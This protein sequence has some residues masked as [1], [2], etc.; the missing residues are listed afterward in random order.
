MW[1]KFSFKRRSCSQ[2]TRILNSET[3]VLS[4]VIDHHRGKREREELRSTSKNIFHTKPAIK[5]ATYSSMME[6]LPIEIPTPNSKIFTVYNWY[7]QPENSHHLQRTGISVSELQPDINVHEVIYADINAHDTAWD[8]TAN[9]NAR[10]EY[11]VNAAMD[12]NRIFHNDQEQP[13]R[14]DPA[15]GTFFSPDVTVVHATFRDIYDLKPH[16]TLSS[17][18]HPILI[19]IHFQTEKL[20]GERFVWD[21][22][23]GDLAVFKPAVDEQL[24]G[25]GLRY[26]ESF[27]RM[28]RSSCKAVIASAKEHIGMKAV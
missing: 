18:H 8:Q 23:K 21:W 13:I 26:G 14:Q 24:R 12:M 28:Y 20:R 5:L 25:S 11:L 1:T 9:L 27:T 3:S 17:A 6:K 22:K 7:L 16:D 19:T 10:G 2:K 4:N 15:T